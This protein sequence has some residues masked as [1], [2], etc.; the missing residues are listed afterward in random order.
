MKENVIMRKSF[1]FSVRIVNLHK[2][3]S[4]EKKESVISK[5]IYR[6]GTSIGANIA[7]AQR[8]QS[9][10][11]F[12]AKMKIALKEANESQYWLQLLH[13]TKYIT[14]KEFQS[15]HND[16]LEILKILTAICKHY[17]QNNR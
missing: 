7:E 12:V 9:T 14:D 8:A 4:Q 1:A 10:A 2:Y 15:I 11:D 16:L 5:Q 3:L 6:S 17:P 13:E